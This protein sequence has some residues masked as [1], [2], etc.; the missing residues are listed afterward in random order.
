[1]KTGK[2]FLW[3]TV[4]QHLTLDPMLFAFLNHTLSGS[5]SLATKIIRTLLQNAVIDP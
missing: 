3:T 4:G 2:D 1:M 5:P